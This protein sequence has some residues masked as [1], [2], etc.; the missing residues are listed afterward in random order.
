LVYPGI[1]IIILNYN[2]KELLSECLP[3]VIKSASNYKGTCV[4]TVLDNCSSDGSDKFVAEH[5]KNVAF[6]K[7]PKNEVL[8]SYNDYIMNYIKEDIVVLLNNDI[9]TDPDFLNPLIKY[10]DKPDTFFA[11]PRQMSFDGLI[12]QGGKHRLNEKLGFMAIGPFFPGYEKFINSPGYTAYTGNGAFRRDVFI[13]LGG[14]D[15]MY[16]PGYVEDADLCFRAWKLGYK[17]YYEPASVIYHK[18]SVTFKNV[19]TDKKRF[20]ISYRN[21]FLFVWKNIGGM[22]LV[23]NILL[24]PFTLMIFVLTGRFLHIEGLINALFKINEI[25]RSKNTIKAEDAFNLAN[26]MDIER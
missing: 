14:F 12:Y 25:R 18:E 16:L 22:R 8:I 5:F 9:K 13:K 21:S 1:N 20:I 7:A 6:Y 2:G 19:Y 3:S 4:I 15:R 26:D 10:F 11:A 17:G 23:K 24:L